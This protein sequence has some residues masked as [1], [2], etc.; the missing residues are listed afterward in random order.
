MELEHGYDSSDVHLPFVIIQSQLLDAN[1][2][3]V[4]YVSMLL[5]IFTTFLTE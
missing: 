3:W 1:L 5:T 4:W 2:L